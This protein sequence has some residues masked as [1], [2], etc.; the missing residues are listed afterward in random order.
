M[1]IG[2]VISRVTILITHI[3]GL[4]TA[5]ITT[6]EPPSISRLRPQNLGPLS[7]ISACGAAVV[8]ARSRLPC[9]PQRCRLEG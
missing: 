8:T 7:P 4:I 2:R 9:R 6:H 3:R 1:V 5:L